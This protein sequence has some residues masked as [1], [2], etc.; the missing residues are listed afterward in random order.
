[1]IIYGVPIF[2]IFTVALF[3]DIELTGEELPSA[4]AMLNLL[5]QLSGCAEVSM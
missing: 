2:R 3:C 5:M 4:E 1:M